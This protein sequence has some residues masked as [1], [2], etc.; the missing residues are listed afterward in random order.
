MRVFLLQVFYLSSGLE[1]CISTIYI[2]MYDLRYFVTFFIGDQCDEINKILEKF[3]DPVSMATWNKAHM[4]DCGDI[5]TIIASVGRISL[6]IILQ[7]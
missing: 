5:T 4:K 2:S 7:V 3:L 1:I 6:H